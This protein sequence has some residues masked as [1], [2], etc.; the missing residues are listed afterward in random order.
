MADA[1][2]TGAGEEPG[3]LSPGGAFIVPPPTFREKRIL[4]RAL[5]FNPTTKDWIRNG[6]IFADLHP[7]DSKVV[8]RLLFALGSVGSMRT[9][10][11]GTRNIRFIIEV[12]LQR[13]VELAVNAA[14]ADMIVSRAVSIQ[15]ITV[16]P[17]AQKGAIVY[18]VDYV[19]LALRDS[20][21]RRFS[22]DAAEGTGELQVPEL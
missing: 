15:K 22:F 9:L 5:R 10:G 21:K 16:D 18:A 4:P 13:Q 12:R 7:N 19:N 2:P 11:N 1:P 8:I 14:L 3:G 17:A 6:A 20:S